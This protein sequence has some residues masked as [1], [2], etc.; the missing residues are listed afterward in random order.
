MSNGQP[1]ELDV[2]PLIEGYVDRVRQELGARIQAWAP[3]VPLLQTQ[4]VLG[5]LMARQVTL[6]T[7]LAQAP[8]IWNGHIAPIILRSMADVYI[9]FAWIWG[10]VEKRC[11]MYVSYGLGQLKLQLEHLKAHVAEQGRDPSM[12]PLI[13][14]F[15]ERLDAERIHA[16]VEVNIGNW[17]GTDMR[18]MAVEANCLDLY[19]FAYSPFSRATHSMWP[20]ISQYNLKPCINPLHRMHRVPTDEEWPLDVDY[21]Y[22]AAKYVDKTM[23]LFDGKTGLEPNTESS[24]RWLAHELTTPES[25][26]ED[27][28]FQSSQAA[29][30][31]S[32]TKDK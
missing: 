7:Q 16:F 32:E 27:E 5:G 17:S 26:P 24:F 21:L 28:I 4:E 9:T 10:D 6:A 19:R 14:T 13:K 20:H 25:E 31:T 3:N 12:D 8:S 30:A 15:Q 11:A 22:R 1:V 29:S 23:R 18:S 2:T